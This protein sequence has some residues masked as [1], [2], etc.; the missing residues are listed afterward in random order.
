MPKILI[1]L[2]INNN[3]N[4]NIMEIDDETGI[5][6]FQK[7]ENNKIDLKSYFLNLINRD[8]YSLIYLEKD[9]YF[10][11]SD[12]KLYLNKKEIH[13]SEIENK[14]FKL[15][16]DNRNKIV[17]FEDFQN[18]WDDKLFF[19]ILKNFIKRIKNKTYNELITTFPNQGY[20]LIIK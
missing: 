11:Y 19:F 14:I 16:I 13:L 17:K 12:N 6:I 3:E 8:I 15:L 18:I 5:K 2:E 20:M 10:N 1:N 7:M 9:F 4:T